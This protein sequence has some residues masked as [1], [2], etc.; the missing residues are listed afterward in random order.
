MALSPVVLPDLAAPAEETMKAIRVHALGG[1]DAL[2]LEDAEIPAPGPGQARLRVEAA[3]L[4]FIEI[5]QRTGLYKGTLP[6]TPGT[7]AA[8]T[9]DAVG[10]GVAGVRVGDRVATVNALGAYAEYTLVPAERL[11]PVPDSVSTRAAAA[12]MLQGMTAE[13]LTSSTF[14]LGSEHVCLLHAAAG[15]VGLLLCQMAKRRG[16][17]VIGT[18]STEEKAALAREAGC[19]DVI[20]YTQT[21]FGAE[22]KRL[23]GGVGVHVV[24]DSVGRTTFAR[25]LDCLTRRG[26]MVLFGQSSGP[27]EPLDPQVLNQRGSLFLTRPTLGHYTATRDELLERAR[28]VLAA[29]GDGSLRV[30]IDRELPLAEAADAHRALEGRGTTGKVLL[31]P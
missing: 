17:R 16:A 10:P 4:N 14:P 27:V 20:L 2:R 9:V 26:M 18:V 30:R 22:V 6:F 8:G 15:G 21:D 11:V 25:G 24:Y 23:T 1:P 13:Y 31:I 5:Y 3:G 29:V 19:D 12:V 28:D 7:E